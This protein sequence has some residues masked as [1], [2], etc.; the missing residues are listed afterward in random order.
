MIGGWYGES[1]GM[2]SLTYGMIATVEHGLE[3][4]GAIVF[5]WALLVHIAETYKQVHFQVDY[6]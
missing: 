4:A 2:Y 3:M 5:I 1:H 6:S